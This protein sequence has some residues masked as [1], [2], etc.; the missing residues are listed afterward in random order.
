MGNGHMQTLGVV[1]LLLICPQT[2]GPQLPFAVSQLRSGSNIASGQPV[3]NNPRG[4]DKAGES[5]KRCFH[6]AERTCNAL[7][8]AT[9]RQT[10][11]PEAKPRSPDT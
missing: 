4:V 5:C 3:P 10:R 11:Q 6:T 2:L 7:C 8:N 9:A 1:E